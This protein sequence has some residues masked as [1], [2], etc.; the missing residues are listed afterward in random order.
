[1]ITV[2]TYSQRCVIEIAAWQSKNYIADPT[3]IRFTLRK[4]LLILQINFN[5]L[6]LAL[7][8]LRISNSSSFLYFAGLIKPIL[9]LSLFGYPLKIWFSHRACC[10]HKTKK[11]ISHQSNKSSCNSFTICSGYVRIWRTFLRVL[12]LVSRM[13]NSVTVCNTASQPRRVTHLSFAISRTL[14]WSWRS[15]FLISNI[16]FS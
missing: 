13:I 12:N 5:Y 16:W 7:W 1:M 9:T 8:R 10:Q 14:S 11:A 15:S 6:Q 3:Q 2:L 4:G